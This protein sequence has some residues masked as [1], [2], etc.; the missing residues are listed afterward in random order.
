MDNGAGWSAAKVGDVNDDASIAKTTKRSTAHFMVGNSEWSETRSERTAGSAL[1]EHQ[2]K[3][4]PLLYSAA[5]NETI[6]GAR[7]PTPADDFPVD[8][9]VVASTGQG[10]GRSSSR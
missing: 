7:D 2:A 3:N 5:A 6:L 4:V 10:L 8:D 1:G 9:F